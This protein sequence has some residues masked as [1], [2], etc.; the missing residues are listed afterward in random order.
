[1][2]KW[3]IKPKKRETTVLLI[4]HNLIW[5]KWVAFNEGELMHGI[6]GRDPHQS[7]PS[8]RNSAHP[9]LFLDRASQWAQSRQQ[10][11]RQ[12]FIQWFIN[13]NE[14]FSMLTYYQWKCDTKLISLSP[15]NLAEWSLGFCALLVQFSVIT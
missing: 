10:E 8:P 13:L 1:M 3:D 2:G 15:V 9:F 6:S 14:T 11:N 7:V 4:T 12:N 5:V